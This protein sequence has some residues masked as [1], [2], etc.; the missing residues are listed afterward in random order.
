MAPSRLRAVA[1]S[2][3]VIGFASCG[4]VCSGDEG[5]SAGYSDAGQVTVR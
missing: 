1:P 3:A 5:D 4:L 2:L